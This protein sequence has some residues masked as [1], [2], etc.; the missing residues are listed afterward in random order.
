MIRKILFSGCVALAFLFSSTTNAVHSFDVALDESSNFSVNIELSVDQANDTTAPT[1]VS[2]IPAAG[3]TISNPPSVIV[4]FSEPVQ[5]VTASSLLCELKAAVNFQALSSTQYLFEYVP[6]SM[7]G[8]IRMKWNPSANITDLSTNKKQFVVPQTVWTYEVNVESG[9]QSIIINEILAIN[10]SVNRNRQGQYSDWV[11]LYNQ[12]ITDVDLGGC[13]LTDSEGD[14]TKWQFPE[15]TV[16]KAGD[17]LLVYCD[18]WTA[19]QPLREYHANF[20]LNKDGEYLGLIEPDGETVVF[21]LA[22]SY[23]KQ[24]SDISFGNGVYYKTPTPGKKNEQGYEAPVSPVMFSEPA[25]YKNDSFTL[26]LSTETEGANIYYTTDGTIPTSSSIL[27][28]ASIKISKITYIRAIAVKDGAIDSPVTTRTWLFMEEVLTQSDSTPAGWPAS[29]AVNNHKMEYGMNSRIVRRNSV[30]IRQGMTNIATFSIVTDLKNLFDSKTGIYVNP[31][32]DGDAWERPVSI[33]LIDPTGGGEFQIDGGLRIRGAYSR[34]SNNPKHSLRFFFRDSYGGK[35]KFPLFGDEGADE[36]DKVDLRTSQNFSW[37]FEHSPYNTFIRETFSRDSQR[38]FGTPYSR[39]RYYHLYINGQYWGL[40]QTEE[41]CDAD[42]AKTYLGGKSDDWDCIKTSHNGYRTEASDGNMNAFTELYNIAVKQGFSGIYSTNYY[43]IKGIDAEGNKIPGSPVYLDEDDL[44]AY[45]LITYFTRDPDCPVAVNSHANNLYGLYNR[46]EPS[47]F[48]WFKHDGEHSMAANRGY[49]VTTDLTAHGWQLNTLANFNPMR[50][51]QRLMDHPEYKMH[52]I[53]LVQKQMLNPDGALSLSNSLARWN[54]RQAEIDQAMIMESARWGHGY[55]RNDWITECNYVKDNFIALSAGYLMKNFKNRG[56]FPTIDAPIFVKKSESDSEISLTLSGSDNVYYTTDGTDPRLVG[57][58]INPFAVKLENQPQPPMTL[59]ERGTEWLYFD[60]GS[61]PVRIGNAS[62]F[63]NNYSH[64]SW[65]KGD[66]RLGFGSRSVKTVL[67]RTS[68]TDGSPIITAYFA[69]RFQVNHANR[70]AGLSMELNVDDGAVVYINGT[71]V[72]LH[73]IKTG[74]NYSTYASSDITGSEENLYHIYEIDSKCLVE[75]ENLI[76]VEVHQSSENNDDLYF[77]LELSTVAGETSD[78]IAGEITVAPGTVLK[79]RCWNGTE[80]SA[81]AE[82]DLT[83]WASPSDLRVSEMMYAPSVSEEDAA[84][85][86]KRDDFAWIEFVNT[87]KGIL[88]LA[89]IQITSGIEY[90]FPELLLY[91]QERVV[92]VKN[93]EAFSS[94]YDTNGMNLLSGYSGNLARKGETI[95]IESPSGENILTYAY[96]NKWYPE[97]DQG[98]YSLVVVDTGAEEAL[99]STAQNWKPSLNLYG[100]PGTEDGGIGIAP[101]IKTQPLSQWI[102]EGKNVLFNVVASGSTPLE[103]Q[104][105]KDGIALLGETSAEFSILNVQ[106][107]DAGEYTVQISNGSGTVISRPAVLKVEKFIPVPPSILVQPQNQSA[108]PKDSVT[109]VVGATGSDPMSY[110]WYKNGI[111]IEGATRPNYTILEVDKNDQSDVYWVVVSNMAGTVE[112]DEVFVTVMDGMILQPGDPI[113]GIAPQNSS[114]P[115]NENP[116]LAVDRDV[117]T[118]YL[119]FGGANAGFIVT[120]QV[121]LS[122]VSGFEITTANDVEGRDP[123]S[124]AIYGTNEAIQSKDGSTGTAE[125][126]NLIAT[127]EISLPSDRYTRSGIMSFQNDSPYLSYK[128]VFPTLKDSSITMVQLA[129]FQFY[130]VIWQTGVPTISP[131]TDY[132]VKEG[133]NLTLIA[134]AMGTLPLSY[135]WYKDGIALPGETDAQLKLINVSVNDSG[136]YT[137]Q[138]SNSEGT[139]TSNE[140]MVKVAAPEPPIPILEYIVEEGRLILNFTGNLYESDDLQNWVPVMGVTS[141]YEV[142]PVSIGSHYYLSVIE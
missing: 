69:K 44:M 124:Y 105:Y 103:Y 37:S 18:S 95:S 21:E 63:Q 56:W 48:K 15:N 80:W 77:D 89:G 53:D 4:N 70:V 32:G 138:V 10:N 73:N 91:P 142:N 71:R 113:F 114:Y 81:I 131:L 23:P 19:D 121:G 35:L 64:D 55:T 99:W 112:S 139:A 65:K 119:N 115:Y 109:F 39:S 94:C 51:H 46:A 74:Y 75:G 104:W 26:E 29:Y 130:G 136:S 49:P 59:I 22:P 16:I 72:L 68:L 122:I 92:L 129:E 52:W 2:M 117:Y 34:S 1:I 24:Y 132:V 82:V 97:T 14:L 126:W 110:Q 137:L 11:E 47:G 87:G 62:W 12:G 58:D 106:L 3:E 140:A 67:N 61:A 30:G 25:G 50:L 13:Y 107:A 85:G 20:S 123:A 127:G 79:S 45:M 5:G 88:N 100:S 101:I 57:G 116:T 6:R 9:L 111:M 102:T 84:M 7:P 28:T 135:Q 38:D 8:S 83:V 31:G 98:G 66:A 108:L 118:K 78:V 125:N 141:P 86:W 42:Y 128:V 134:T 133:R 60:N 27:Y 43:W 36:F 33:E 17:Y 54:S 40:Y 76:A 120:P 41:R 96:S 93:L 90:T